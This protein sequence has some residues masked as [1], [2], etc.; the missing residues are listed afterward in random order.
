MASSPEAAAVFAETQIPSSSFGPPGTRWGVVQGP[1]PSH[2]RQIWAAV[3]VESCQ[4]WVIELSGRGVRATSGRWCD[5]YGAASGPAASL[6]VDA[7]GPG[8]AHRLGEWRARG[9]LL[10]DAVARQMLSPRRWLMAWRTGGDAGVVAVVRLRD[11]RTTMDAQTTAALQ[12]GTEHWLGP[13]LAATARPD[14]D[15][16]AW[17]HVD[18][19]ARPALPRRLLAA[20]VMSLLASGLGLWLALGVANDTATLDERHGR[21]LILAQS[22]ADRHLSLGLS[23]L[24]AIGDYGEV[25]ELL[26]D[27]A[28]VGGWTGAVVT[29]ARNQV[30][31]HVGSVDAVRLGTPPPA[32][33][34]A[35]TRS[36]Q[37]AKGPEPLGSLY[38]AAG[39][40]PGAATALAAAPTAAAVVLALRVGGALIACAG[41][42]VALLLLSQLRRQRGGL[43]SDRD[44][45]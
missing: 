39:P 23:H 4:A 38:L 30:V 26:N 42:V 40:A 24:L 20:L 43:R 17:D 33:F 11:A 9:E 27:K 28:Q 21:A 29:N 18:R 31:A 34:L 1:L 22:T 14:D 13:D 36:L 44:V 6:D 8:V 45:T 41:A 3:G 2:Q 5:E 19:R 35:T 10:P 16:H 37:L 15:V 12:L 32:A 7:A 25:Q